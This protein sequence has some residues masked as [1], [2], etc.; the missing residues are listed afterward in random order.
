DQIAVWEKRWQAARDCLLGP[1]P[2]SSRTSEALGIRELTP[3]PWDRSKCT[4]LVA[5]LTR[6]GVPDTGIEE[7]EASWATLD[8]AAATAAKSSA[9]HVSAGAPLVDDPLPAALDALDTARDGVR[10]AAGLSAE[11]RGGSP[12]SAAQVVEL[13]DAGEAVLELAP[14]GLPSAH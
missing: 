4:P 7:V 9:S 8:H 3:D 12:L 6:G 2:G 1:S 5:K 14:A 11:H 13:S 10:A